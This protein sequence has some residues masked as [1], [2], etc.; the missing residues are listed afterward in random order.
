M[1]FISNFKQPSNHLQHSK[2]IPSPLDV[3]YA[4]IRTWPDILY[5]ISYLARFMANPKNAHWEMVKCVVRDLKGTEDAKLILRK[6]GTLTWE[7]LNY[8][9]CY[10]MKGYSNADGSSQEHHHML[11]SYIFC[12][13]G[14]AISWNSR[15]QTLMLLSTMESKNIAMMHATKEALWIRMFLGE[16]LCPLTKLMLLYCDNHLAITIAKNDQYHACTKHIGI[17]YHYVRYTP[18]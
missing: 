7:V 6:G 17:W 5:A 10:R 13:D 2:M 14:G 11:S 4:V 1:N 12:I 15:K 3:Q 16:I 8:K 9:D 18:Q